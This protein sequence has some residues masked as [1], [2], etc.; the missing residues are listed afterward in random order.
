M[1]ARSVKAGQNDKAMRL[2]QQMQQEG[3][4]P[5]GF[6]FVQVLKA[7]AS[8]QALEKDGVST[9]RLSKVGVSWMSL[10]VTV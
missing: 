7:C 3:I 4:V 10:L 1:L 9:S 6:S 2:F 5:N 8:L